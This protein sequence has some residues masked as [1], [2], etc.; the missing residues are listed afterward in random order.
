[1]GKQRIPQFLLPVLGGL[2][3]ASVQAAQPA[4]WPVVSGNTA[5]QRFSPLSDINRDNVGKLQLAWEFRHGDFSNGEKGIGPSAGQVTPL[6][7]D[8]RMYICTP[9]S[10]VV[11]LDAETGKQQWSYDPKTNLEGVYTPSCRG[12]SYWRESTAQA[13]SECSERILA[14]T[15]DARLIALDAR[16]GKT[17]PGFG[18]D[19][20]VNLLDGL[21]DVEPGEYYPTSPPLIL[22]DKIITNAFVKD[23]QR[24]DSPSGAIRAFDVRTGQ[25]RWAWDPVPPTFPAVTAEQIAQGATLTRGTPNSWG[26]MSA[27]EK[28]GLVF[29]PTGNPSPD[30]YGG[31]ERRGFDYYGTSVVALDAETG[32]VRWNFQTVHH[33][34]WDYDVAAQ[35]VLF[36]HK[37]QPAVIGATK[38]G[39]VF[40][41]DRL[42]GKPL[43]PV[44]ER[45]VPASAIPGETLSPTQPFPTRPGPLLPLNMTRD[46]VWGMTPI[47][48]KACL[49]A[50][51]ALDYEGIYTPP[52]FK[53]TLVYPGIGGGINWGSV[54][55][56]PVKNRMV[57]NMQV[58]PFTVQLVPREQV[59]DQS[60]KGVDQVGFNP[61]KGTPYVVKRG[62]YI[63]PWMTPCVPTPWG[64]L[65]SV[66]LNTGDVLWERTLGNLNGMAPL[67]GDWLEWGTPNTGG[68]IQTA[69]G[70]IFVAATMDKYLRAFD[71]DTGEEV[72]RYELPFAG[73]ATPMTYRARE[74]GKQYLVISAGGHGPLGATAGDAVVAFAL[75]D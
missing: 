37:G 30:H 67:I 70:L 27:D 15:L 35:P 33:D 49:E 31:K 11:A 36:E 46:D 10:R 56:D 2:L 22:K 43:F 14:S 61:Q 47:D 19:G 75:P 64:K 71:A 6:V 24:V 17:C 60:N 48:K 25:L 3:A 40:L 59:E 54:S 5:G 41:L 13:G 42:T 66:D 51:D 28:N 58:A 34:V 32:Q 21:G 26:L 16:T 63:S 53:G 62:L 57:A 29:V 8:G 50:F 12:V 39:F 72:W 9:F 52:T 1:M 73:M 20:Q 7:V 68:T 18:K 69:G 55:V 23:G 74:N 4:E 44:E 65:V 38:M 45:P